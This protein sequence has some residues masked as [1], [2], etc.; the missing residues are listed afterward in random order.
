MFQWQMIVALIVSFIWGYY[1]ARSY[2]SAALGGLLLG[3][4]SWHVS[5]IAFDLLW[6]GLPVSLQWEG[7]PMLWAGVALALAPWI[8]LEIARTGIPGVLMAIIARAVREK[9]RR[10]AKPPS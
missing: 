4:L 2:W 5:E 10:R 3:S 6:R 8:A 1:V 7:G 9:G